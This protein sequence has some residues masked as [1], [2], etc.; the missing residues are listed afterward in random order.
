MQLA[1]ETVVATSFGVAEIFTVFVV[2]LCVCARGRGQCETVTV[3]SFDGCAVENK[4]DQQQIE[5]TR[6][7]GALVFVQS[8]HAG[9]Y[10]LC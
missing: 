2:E 10:W 8:K 6:K 3:R 7:S 9:P 1:D 4:D 5:P